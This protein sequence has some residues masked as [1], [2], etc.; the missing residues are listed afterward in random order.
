MEDG[1]TSITKVNVRFGALDEKL[2]QRRDYTNKRLEDTLEIR[3]VGFL[4]SAGSLP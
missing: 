4:G 2:T 3:E 1:L